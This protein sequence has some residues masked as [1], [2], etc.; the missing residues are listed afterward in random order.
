M[1][2]FV[3]D[4]HKEISLFFFIEN[5]LSPLFLFN[6]MQ[7]LSKDGFLFLRWHLQVLIPLI[8]PHI[9]ISINPFPTRY[10]SQILKNLFHKIIHFLFRNIPPALRFQFSFFFQLSL[11]DNLLIRQQ[12]SSVKSV[13]VN[14]HFSWNHRSSWLYFL[15]LMVI[16]I[17]IEVWLLR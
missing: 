4:W 11:F 8:C 1:F 13:W 3:K 12:F 5:W 17:L 15:M 10:N 2:I 16:L 9:P 14:M 7:I 6:F